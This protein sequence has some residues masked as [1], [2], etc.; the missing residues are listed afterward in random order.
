MSY[1][2]LYVGQQSKTSSRQ[3]VTNY[4]NGTGTA[5]AQGSPCS[6]N[7]FG[8]IVPTDVT[9][10]TSVQ[11]FVGYA[12]FRIPATASGP[13]IS[14]G[15]LENIV[16]SFAVGDAIYMGIST[17]LINTKPADGL[18]GFTVDD[19]VIFVG[20]L[21]QNEFNPSLTDIQLFTQNIGEL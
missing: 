1:N 13:V 5:I 20:V 7:T 14:S 11:A 8:Q 3:V 18:Y 4:T 15:R 12:Q 21:V 6:T 9:D 19:F 10:Q 17:P 16:T 2:P